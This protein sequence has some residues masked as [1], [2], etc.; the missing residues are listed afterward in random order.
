MP[1]RSLGRQ[2][3]ELEREVLDVLWAHPD[4]L[5]TVRDV[6]A[7]ISSRREIAY[8]TA[9]TVMD[10]M[11]KKGLLDQHRTGRAYTYQAVGTRADLT[12]GLMRETLAQVAPEHRT[13]ALVAFVGEAD[14]TELAA[15][16]S[17]LAAIEPSSPE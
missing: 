10:R 11:A 16:R 15:L 17:A 14:D 13:H 3:G 4:Q 5:L 1:N 7:E 12:A 8:T 9:M 2:L 6:H